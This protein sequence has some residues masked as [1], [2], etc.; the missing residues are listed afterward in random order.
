MH[1]QFLLFFIII[2]NLLNYGCGQ[3]QIITLKK[4]NFIS[5]DDKIDDNNVEKWSK[6]MN[7]LTANPIYIFI[8]SPGG[9]VDAG[10]Q[11][12]NNMNWLINHDKTINCIVKSAYSMAF[13]I[14]QHCTNRYVMSSSTLMQHQMSLTGLKGPINNLMNYLEMI[15]NISDELDN[16]VSTRL[17]MTVESYRNKIKN[18]WWLTGYSA[19]GAGVVDS[20][21]IVGCDTELYDIHDN[22]EEIIFDIDTKGNLE[23]KKINTIKDICPL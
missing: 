21:V 16:K 9:S 6:Q 11:F 8:D 4:N 12:I 19:L 13:V 1:I 18:D 23:I 20:M 14:L 22:Q 15:S 10:S 7:K 17:N 2:L 5:I 3:N